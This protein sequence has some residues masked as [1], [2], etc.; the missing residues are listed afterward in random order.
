MTTIE[1]IQDSIITTVNEFFKRKDF[2]QKAL[3]VLLDE[4]GH[5]ILLVTDAKN[6][7]SSHN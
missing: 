1:D 7:T 5:D 3:C 6:D 4:L 2:N